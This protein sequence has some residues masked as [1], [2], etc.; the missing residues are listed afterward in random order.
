MEDEKNLKVNR[1]PGTVLA[2]GAHPDDVEIS[3]AGTLKLLRDQGCEIHIATMTLGDCGS[4]VH[5]AEE[6][7]EIR[8]QE[9][10][11]AASMLPAAYHYVGSHDF[12]I[13]NDDNHN[14]LVTA[15]IREVSPALVLTHAPHDY[16]TDHETTSV[17]VR[18]ACFYAPARNYHTSAF[19][20]TGPIPAIPHLYYWDS[21]EGVD[22]FGRPTPVQMLA[23][24]TGQIDL[25][26][27]MLARH[28]SQRE[29]LR[30][31]HGMDE[32]I[33]SMRAW[34]ASRGAMAARLAGRP[35]HFAEAFQQ[36]LGHAYPRTNVLQNMLGSRAIPTE[37]R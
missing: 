16:I 28:R 2:V 7:R 5:P 13:F 29:W 3:C 14:R 15:L 1:N 9:A 37:V 10:E 36:H 26:S 27:S 24:I 18:N 31:H 11:T 21:M 33:E 30:Q 12:S 23:D 25:K 20:Q 6:I 32:Y 4:D 8:R 34:G 22:I 19:G 17:L 35:I